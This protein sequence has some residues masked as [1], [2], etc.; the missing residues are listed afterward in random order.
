MASVAI[1][2]SLHRAC[3]AQH[4]SIE[5]KHRPQ[6]R[7][8][9]SLGSKQVTRVVT[10]NVERQKGFSQA[11]QQEKSTLEDEGSK[12]AEDSSEHGS[13]MES[14]L[15]RFMDERWN[16]GN[17]DLNK[18]VKEGKMDW[19]S[20]IVAEAK[21]RKFLE[22]Y[23]EA[24]SNE[25]QV[26]FKSSIIPWWAWLKRAAMIGFFMAYTVDGLTGLELV[27]QTG[28]L[29]CKAGLF[30]T[31]IAILLFR[32]TADIE[33]LKKLAEEATFYDKQWQASWQNQDTKSP[34]AS[35]KTGNEV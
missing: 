26:L 13:G 7:P 22:L 8:A 17:W 2:A 5:K 15:P 33:N 31:V 27:G 1:S 30:F 32:K 6:T 14:S 29:L 3:C 19:D 16:M 24:S 21:R 25:E 28:N 11:E 34:V 9:R 23:P 35:E 4:T 10:I 18:F 12:S 20:L